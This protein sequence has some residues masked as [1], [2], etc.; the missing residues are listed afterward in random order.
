MI[1]FFFA[2]L[3]VLADILEEVFKMQNFA[4]MRT[5]KIKTDAGVS[6]SLSH[7]LRVRETP[8]ADPEIKNWSNTGEGEKGLNLALNLYR[9]K[10]PE[11]I[12]KN[13]VRCV[14]L[15]MTASPDAFK[16]WDE[17]TARK[18]LNRCDNWARETFGA[19][20]VFHVSHH[21]DE[22]TP[23]TSVF[24]VPK[25]DGKLNARH[26]L[27]GRDKLTELQ[28]SFASAVCSEFSLQRGVEGSKSRHEDIKRVYGR[29]NALKQQIQ[30]PDKKPFEKQ[31]EYAE[32]VKADLLPLLRPALQ[33]DAEKKKVEQQKK[34][35]Q[36]EIKNVEKLR[37]FSKILD[38]PQ[39]LRA[40]ADQVEQQKKQVLEQQKKQVQTRKNLNSGFE[41]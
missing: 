5:A 37:Q 40:L 25:K 15:I 38:S 10:L 35:V 9:E 24:V 4:I 18:Y 34:Q 21:W 30:I 33:L 1:S 8:N 12:R 29:L 28:T 17:K 7:A 20:N 3:S 31:A 14:E 11:K 22:K 2:V 32:R 16:S 27:G 19:D 26:W 39:A 41:R 23:H 36:A 13:G 6:S